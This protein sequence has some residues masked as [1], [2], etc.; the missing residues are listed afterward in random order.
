MVTSAQPLASGRDCEVF[1]LADGRVARSYRDGRSARAEAELIQTVHALGYP[2]PRVDE[3]DGPRIVME[4]I[5]GP[6]LGEQLLGGAMTAEEA[7]R[8]QADL[9]RR[10]HALPW[11]GGQPL[12]HLD[13][14]PL[15]VLMAED[16]PVVID[17]TNAHAGPPG[18]D[19]AMSALILAAVA[20]TGEFAAAGQLLPAY[21]AA[22]PT[23][24]VDHLD[25]AA[26]IRTSKP[27]TTADEKRLMREA[28]ELARSAQA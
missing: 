23:P 21:G 15:N 12:L 10:L 24:Y 26:R 28:V 25:E 11:P 4:C 22:A 5:S 7:A 3:W 1:L 17:W 8:T 6:T 13:F 27:H 2:V 14:H 19:V 18:L 20:L 16:G 9:Q